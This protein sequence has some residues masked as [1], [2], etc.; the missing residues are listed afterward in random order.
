MIR[1]FW[2][3]LKK[4]FRPE[5]FEIKAEDWETV[6]DDFP[7]VI[8]LDHVLTPLAIERRGSGC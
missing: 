8:T 6:G 1:R 4:W 7:T 5:P 2:A 3:W